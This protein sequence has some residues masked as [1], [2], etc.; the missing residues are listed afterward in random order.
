MIVCHRIRF[1][2]I[3]VSVLV[4]SGCISSPPKYSAS[5]SEIGASAPSTYS[6][7]ILGLI[8]TANTE[9]SK[10]FLQKAQ[11][12][13]ESGY[14]WA[15]PPSTF[16]N[17]MNGALNSRFAKVVQ[18]GNSEDAR[19]KGASMV[20]VFDAKVKVGQYTGQVTSV[21]I[22]GVFK[23]LD[24][25][26]IDRVVV[27]A[28]DTIP[29]PNIDN[30]Y[31]SVMNGA[32]AELAKAIDIAPKLA[33]YINSFKLAQAPNLPPASQ[34]R[35]RSSPQY[36]FPKGKVT[37]SDAIAVIVGNKS[38]RNRDVPEVSFAQNDAAAISQ[39]VETT[40]GFFRRNI[41][42]LNNASQ[43]D[44]RAYFGS[45][46]NPQGRLYDMV[47]PG[48]SDVFV[49]YSGHGMPGK[50]RSGFLLPVDADPGK[51]ELT[52]YAIDTLV[53][54]LGKARAR[55]ITLAMDT[56]FSG[57]SDAGPLIRDA[58][59]VFI[60]ARNTVAIEN[61]LVISA[62][63]GNQIASWDRE[64]QL[65]LFTRY[66]LTGLMGDA[67]GLTGDK[68]GQISAREIEEYL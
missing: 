40:M 34:T 30:R 35:P 57:L 5:V 24:G 49:F 1:F 43:S 8:S 59:P 61:G 44:L 68:D 10:K 14:R 2:C 56:C 63:N 17:A 65:G 19:G 16:T 3:L 22:L 47:R 67:D 13:A 27:N 7:I 11:R 39:F 52:G 48:Q 15:V 28:S 4:T 53:K 51:P 26:E 46:G 55:R 41:V 9:Q 42:V 12:E 21:D 58:S 66:L 29:M 36:T 18:V 38:Y 33:G 62:A 20:L 60:E 45:E 25:K 37:N 64:A 6:S 54:N 31:A 23:S 50:N 32:A